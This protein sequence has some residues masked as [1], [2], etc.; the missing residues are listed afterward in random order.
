MAYPMRALAARHGAADGA[1]MR[2]LLLALAPCAAFSL[3][4][5]VPDPSVEPP[6]RLAL[7][8]DGK[9][10]ALVDGQQATIPI[11]GR[12]TT[13]V[14]AV[15]P[16]RRF[17]AA[18]IAFDYPRSMAF[19]F[20][21]DAGLTSWTLDGNDTVVLV[22]RHDDG[23]AQVLARSM[24]SSVVGR[25]DDEAEVAPCELRLGGKL[26]AGFEATA[27]IGDTTIRW[28][29][30]GLTVAGHAVVLT[31]QDSLDDGKQSA[32]TKA[33]LELLDRTLVIAPAVPAGR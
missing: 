4:R 8:I 15:E 23:E 10:H 21:Q 11:G 13:V 18:G 5:V 1:A 9:V 25:F 33:V 17:D 16:M 7:R 12:P 26:V 2:S 6:L 3:G 19:E 22:H 24:L 20:E 28:L 14:V 31:V 32:E 30:A 27:V 29:T